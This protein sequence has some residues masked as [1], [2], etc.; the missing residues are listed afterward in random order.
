MPLILNLMLIHAIVNRPT[1]HRT[2]SPCNRCERRTQDDY[3]YLTITAHLDASWTAKVTRATKPPRNAQTADVYVPSS[4]VVAEPRFAC[5]H[6][7]TSAEAQADF[8]VQAFSHFLYCCKCATT[9]SRFYAASWQIDYAVS[10]FHA[11]ICSLRG[12]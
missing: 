2:L 3:L 8:L 7:F 11:L 5:E 6:K 9:R 10:T 1:S 12:V 4:G